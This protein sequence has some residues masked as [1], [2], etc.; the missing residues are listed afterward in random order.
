[1]RFLRVIAIVT[2]AATGLFGFLLLSGHDPA[3]ATT[4]SRCTDVRTA[5][6]TLQVQAKDAAFAAQRQL[7]LTMM[8]MVVNDPDCFP[9]ELVAAAQV[10]LS[11]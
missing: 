4:T 11:H 10:A 9:P 5:V 7:N 8:H 3:R 6:G 1:M 2:L